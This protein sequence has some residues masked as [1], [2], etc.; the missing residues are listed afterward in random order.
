MKKPVNSPDRSR[1]P[2]AAQPKLD[3]LKLPYEAWRDDPLV[4]KVL[5][6]RPQLSPR[7]AVELVK[8]WLSVDERKGPLLPVTNVQREFE[9]ALVERENLLYDRWLDLQEGNPDPTPEP[10]PLDE[11]LVNLGEKLWQELTRI[12]NAWRLRLAPGVPL[13][14]NLAETLKRLS[15]ERTGS[16]TGRPQKG[17]KPPSASPDSTPHKR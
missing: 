9:Q 6:E 8:K 15:K 4:R 14:K 3:P 11:V 13:P 7:E 12:P 16:P 1:R 5:R 2:S 17:A 10:P